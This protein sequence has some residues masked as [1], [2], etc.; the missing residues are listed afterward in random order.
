MPLPQGVKELSQNRFDSFVGLIRAPFMGVFAK[1]IEWYSSEHENVLG[2]LLFDKTDEDYACVVLGRDTVGKFRAIHIEASHETQ[3]IARDWLF[4]KILWEWINGSFV[5]PQGDED[6]KIKLNVFTPIVPSE[7]QHPYY[8]I[9]SS[10]DSH[11]AARG[12]IEEM[13]PH[14]IDIDGNFVQQFQSNGFDSRLWELYLFAYLSESKFS[15]D[16]SHHAPD[17]IIDN[18]F[19][20]FAIEAVIV[21]RKANEMPKMINKP[22]PLGVMDIVKKISDEMPIKFGSPLFTKLQK[23]YW[24][25][26]HAKNLPLVLAIADFHDDQSMLWSS[27]ALIAYLYGL[28][29]KFAFNE[30]GEMEITP[31]KFISH[32]HGTKTIPS[33]FF[34]QPDTENISA[35]LFSASG[36]LSKFNRLGVQAGFGARNI[37]MVRSGTRHDSNPLSTT[38][39]G[40]SYEVTVESMETWAEG[41]N[42]FHNPKAKNPIPFDAFPY[43][44]HH[45]IEGEKLKSLL[46][47][48]HPYS[49]ITKIIKVV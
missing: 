17:F 44:A 9:L 45:F 43:I 1:E 20:K 23:R 13:M 14:Y 6:P 42:M 10:Q 5:Y 2:V 47:E 39:L 28:G 31:K 12:I 37:R 46:P 4:R 30:R 33:V 36:T 18:H 7:N 41:M 3:D 38:P 11:K 34:A 48:F 15:F 32:T 24:E 19:G 26:D 8:R 27:T 25:L 21:G 40:F 29:S 16:R 35:V 49:S 22:R